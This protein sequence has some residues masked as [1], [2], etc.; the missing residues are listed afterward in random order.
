MSAWKDVF[1]PAHRQWVEAV[2][3][4]HFD[5][6]RRRRRW[7]RVADVLLCVSEAARDERDDTHFTADDLGECEREWEW[8]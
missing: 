5:L 6:K 2:V 4:R 1:D 3:R 7:T 8:V